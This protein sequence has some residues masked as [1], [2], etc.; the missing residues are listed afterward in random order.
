MELACWVFLASLDSCVVNLCPWFLIRKA[1]WYVLNWWIFEYSHNLFLIFFQSKYWDSQQRAET[2][3]I[4]SFEISSNLTIPNRQKHLCPN[5]IYRQGKNPENNIYF[6]HFSS[7]S[8]N[9]VCAYIMPFFKD[10]QPKNQ[11]S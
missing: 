1:I 8:E 6:W 11:S 7:Y 3:A 10:H 4:S 9:W 2:A 5:K